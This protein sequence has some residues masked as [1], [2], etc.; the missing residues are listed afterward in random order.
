MEKARTFFVSQGKKL[1]LT[2]VAL[3]AFVNQA[4]AAL[5]LE[6]KDAITK[7]GDDGQEMIGLLWPVVTAITIGFI[8]IR[9]FKKGANKAV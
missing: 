6:V 5:P 8:L 9:L 3:L 4:M 2:G 1:G 7:V